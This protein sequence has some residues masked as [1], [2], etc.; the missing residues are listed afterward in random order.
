MAEDTLQPTLLPRPLDT[1]DNTPG[2]RALP[3]DV[4]DYLRASKAP[5]T[6]RGYRSDWREF[7][8]WCA[9]RALEPLPASPDDVA[10]Y[11]A[12]CA[13]RLKPGSIQRRLN[14][15]AEAHKAAGVESPTQAPLVRNVMKGIRRAKGTA[16]AQKAAAVTDDIR[17]MVAATAP[18]LIG[19]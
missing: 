12:D 9:R 13:A 19:L 15:I 7:C 4:R 8:V 3:D 16:P 14:A 2:P 10:A 1:C 6:L 17:A 5:N 18:G 11:I